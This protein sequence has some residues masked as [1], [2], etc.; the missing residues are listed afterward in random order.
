[1]IPA[2]LIV[3]ESLNPDGGDPTED[4]CSTWNRAFRDALPGQV[5]CMVWLDGTVSASRR[6]ADGMWEPAG[7]R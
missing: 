3:P 1:M 7:R 4:D 6:R 2:V 5:V